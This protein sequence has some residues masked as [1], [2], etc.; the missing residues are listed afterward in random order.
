MKNIYK[1][2]VS[3]VISLSL[4]SSCSNFDDLNTNPDTT[5]QVSPSMLC[6]NAILRVLKFSGRDAMAFLS[7]NGLPKYIC[8]ANQ[9]QMPTQYNSI[10]SS[11][12]GMMTILPNLE[13]MIKAS[14]GTAMESSYRGVAKYV[15]AAVFYQM[16]MQMGD[17]PYSEAN[18]AS[19]GKYRPKYD[20]QESVL[21]GILAEL[22]EAEA[23]FAAG[24]N[25]T[26]D[27]TPYNGNVEKW[28]R[29]TNAFALNVLMSL[30]NK[31][32]KSDIDIK[33]LFSKIHSSGMLL[34]DE[35]GFLGLEYSTINKHPLNGT[36]DLFTSRTILSDVV[37]DELK[38][39]NDYRL[40]YLGEPA[41]AK[42]SEGKAEN[43]FDAYIGCDP[44][45][46]YAEMTAN[47]LENKYSLI[48]F[49]Y[50]IEDATEPYI[51][52]SYA[53]QQLILSEAVLRGWIS[54]S[55]ES[56]YKQGV[57]SI[58]KQF[59]KVNSKYAH[60]R[61]IDDA[62]IA[63]YFKGEAAFKAAKA[64]QLKQIWMQR[65]LLNFFQNSLS[66]YFEYR[67]NMYP[68]FPINPETS[69]NQNKK[70]A[71]PVRWLY[72]GSE[73]S[74]NRAN[75]EEALNRQFDGYDEINKI[76]WVLK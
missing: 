47:H 55:A 54:G 50:R 56:F 74:V 19:I 2:I 26:G 59:K 57:S 41:G 52:M 73:T 33:G 1:Y 17:I 22:T 72:P 8:F 67:R 61:N 27:P 20:T 21:K 71:L 32:G 37:V 10:G 29:A 68:E 24:T 38:K 44:S 9:S 30:S 69:L 15:K 31:E 35:T 46:D 53:E 7:D 76:M 12:F 65:Y 4:F 45:L 36:N 63:D 3:G 66:S 58:L 75:L 28:R 70:D 64:D 60:G 40:F 39:L 34:T 42:L 14:Q 16:T 18:Q 5:T 62:Y 43:D 49:R 11:D 48:N 13:E 23:Y 6:T 25:F 51:T